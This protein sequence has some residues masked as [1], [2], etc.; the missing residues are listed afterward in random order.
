MPAFLL[1]PVVIL[2]IALALA[3]GVAS[4]YRSELRVSE[5]EYAAFRSKVEAL[6]EAAKANK[7]IKEKADAD[8][9]TVAVSERDAARNRLRELEKA[10]ASQRSLPVLPAATERTDRICL[11][12]AKFE[13]AFGALHT[14]IQG[15]AQTGNFAIIDN[16]AWLS[17]WPK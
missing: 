15:I 10:G 8:K 11:S 17:A 14:D 5:A 13:S 6:G 2:G 12:R 16:K 1:N 9:I 3:L 7:V 4:H